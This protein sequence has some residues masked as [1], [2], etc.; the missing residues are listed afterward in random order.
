M[1]FRL[2]RPCDLCYSYSTL[3][4]Q[5]LHKRM[6]MAVFQFFPFLYETGGV[7]DLAH[8]LYFANLESNSSF[9]A[10]HLSYKQCVG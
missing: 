10:L 7:L 9:S 8:K 5:T 6:R 2:C 1:Y 3:Q 4:P